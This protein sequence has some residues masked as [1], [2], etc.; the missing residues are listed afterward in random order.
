MKSSRSSGAT[1]L[2]NLG[3]TTR[4]FRSRAVV[5]AS[6]AFAVAVGITGALPSAA[7]AAGQARSSST[8]KGAEH[9]QSVATLAYDLVSA[10]GTVTSFGHAGNFGGAQGIHLAAPIVGMATTPDGLGYWLVARDGG[11]F[12]F[13]DARFFGS[14]G[15]GKHTAAHDEVAIVPTV[16]GE[17]YWLCDASGVVTAFGDAPKLPSLLPSLATVPIVGISVLHDQKGAWVVNA[18]GVVFHLGQSYVYGSLKGKTLAQPIVGMARTSNGRGYWLTDSKGDVFPFGH[19][20]P[21][22][23]ARALKAPIVAISAAPEG[24]GYWAVSAGGYVIPG[25]VPS[26]G[27]LARLSG[28]LLI[29]GIATAPPLTSPAPSPYPPGSVG[30]DVNWPQCEKAGSKATGVMP[31]PPVDPSGTAAYSVAILGVDGW[32][33]S[34]YNSCLAAEVR[35]ADKATV[36]GSTTPPAYQLYLFLNSPAS[37]STIDEHGPA[38]TCAS[39][40]AKDEPTCLA[41]NYGYNSA[42]DAVT[43]AASEGASAQMWWLDIENDA[44]APGEWNAAG[45]GEWWSCE[46]SLND[47]TIQG[48]LDALHADK[49]TAGVYSTALQWNAITGHYVPSGTPVPLW[50]AGAVWTSPPFPRSYGYLATTA[51]DP[52]CDGHYDFA[53]GTP[54]LLQETPGSNDYPYDPDYAC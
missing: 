23:A 39:V 1:D 46:Q 48:A 4:P 32:A 35:W 51:L 15:G 53:G 40:A 44:C 16:D 7:T 54:S 10:N 42:L 8:H 19:A 30:Y 37:T 27:G 34:D 9:H 3:H 33:V 50:I 25:G 52:W 45:D 21:A 18:D 49:V 12:T 31:G 29:V 47:L 5:A 11:V 17:G 38:G 28:P 43:Y 14:L 26:R 20:T 2:V 6:I 13:G 41:Y 24:R 22:I 36:A